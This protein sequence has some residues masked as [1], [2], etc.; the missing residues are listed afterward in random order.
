VRNPYAWMARSKVFVLSS[1]H[2]GCPNVLLEALA[3]GCSVVATDAPGDARF[4][5]H[6]GGTLGRLVPVGDWHEMAQAIEA[7]L[8]EGPSAARR[9]AVDESLQMFEPR[10]T[11]IAYLAAAG[12]SPQPGGWSADIPSRRTKNHPNSNCKVGP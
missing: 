4:L 11:A 6:N 5:L 3:C 9:S 10:A 7:A 12:L 2:E 1:V 8:D